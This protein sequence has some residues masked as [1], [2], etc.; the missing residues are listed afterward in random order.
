[1]KTKSNPFEVTATEIRDWP[2]LV[3]QS[4]RRDIPPGAGFVQINLQS[5]P[6]GE[7]RVRRGLRPVTFDS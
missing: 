1:M 6:P 5:N 2:G 3:T 7:L 4:D